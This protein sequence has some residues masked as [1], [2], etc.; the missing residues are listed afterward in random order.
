MT[1]DEYF[2]T[3][4][5]FGVLATAGGDGKVN[6]AVF[7]RPHVMD[8]HN[9]A[10]IMAERLTYENLRSNPW[11]TYI[12]LEAGGGWAG[13]RLYL[14]KIREEENE[15]LRREIC[16]RCDYS[17]YDVRKRFIVHFLIERELPLIGAGEER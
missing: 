8:E 1:M 10:F 13:K 16:R 15:E 5:G 11:A 4:K 17:R 3:V 12:F 6:A 7:A 2:D 9:V 14:R